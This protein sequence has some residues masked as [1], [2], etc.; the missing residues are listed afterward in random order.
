MLMI[1][2]P[3]YEVAMFIPKTIPKLFQ[4]GKW[5]TTITLFQA[6][7]EIK[8]NKPITRMKLRITL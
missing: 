5:Q 6:T 3:I 8:N 2:F 4:F 1:F 7:N